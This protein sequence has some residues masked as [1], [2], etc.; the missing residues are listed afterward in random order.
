MLW[1]GEPYRPQMVLLYWHKHWTL[2]PLQTYD[3]GHR[4]SDVMDGTILFLAHMPY[5]GM[6]E[7]DGL[8]GSG[9]GEE[10]ED[11]AAALTAG[12]TAS[13]A[14]NAAEAPLPELPMV[15]TNASPWTITP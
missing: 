9:T 2:L 14:P 8:R 12:A 4:V 6:V 1:V 3:P 13:L 5:P 15:H 10:Q 7:P 11:A